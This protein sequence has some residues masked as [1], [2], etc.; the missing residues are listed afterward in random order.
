MF[1]VF[2]APALLEADLDLA[3]DLLEIGSC[4]QGWGRRRNAAPY[5]SAVALSDV[6]F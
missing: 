1:A 6:I 2:A 3:F 4:I 5:D